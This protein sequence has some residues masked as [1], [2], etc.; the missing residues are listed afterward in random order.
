VRGDGS[1]AEILAVAK[2]V[3]DGIDPDLVYFENKTMEEHLALMLFPAR[4]GALILAAFGALALLLAGIGIYG[5]VSYAVASRTRELGVRMSLGA[6]ARDV[7][8]LAVGGGMRLVLFG[9]ALGLLLAAGVTWALRSFLFGIAATDL[10]TF[11][12]IPLLLTGVAFVAALI[13]ARR[14]SQV[15]PVGAL[16]SD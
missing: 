13:P 11:A 14:A 8:R 2:Q 7:V 5:V 16:R 3:F 15:D 4:M 6:T 1:S 12:V 10:V 9:G